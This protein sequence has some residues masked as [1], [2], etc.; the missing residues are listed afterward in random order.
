MWLQIG[1]G[2]SRFVV[3]YVSERQTRKVV[4]T[5]LPFLQGVS[6]DFNQ[7]SHHQYSFDK[8]SEGILHGPGKG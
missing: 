8:E 7:V 6:D 3:A 4:S 2:R 5:T 1:R